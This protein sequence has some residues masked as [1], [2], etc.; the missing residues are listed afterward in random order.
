MEKLHYLSNVVS[1]VLSTRLRS[2]EHHVHIHVKKQLRD[3]PRLHP[4]SD[5]HTKEA[6]TNLQATG[7]ITWI[8]LI[9]NPLSRNE[10]AQHSTLDNSHENITNVT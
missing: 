2:V 4:S 7:T 8:K 9:Q 5:P 10:H 1:S 3:L 6:Q